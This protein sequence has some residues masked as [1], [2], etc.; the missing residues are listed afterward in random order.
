MANFISI[1]STFIAILNNKN[2]K[3]FEIEKGNN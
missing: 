2:I 3:N 1:V